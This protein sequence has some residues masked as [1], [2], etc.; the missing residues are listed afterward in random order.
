MDHVPH[1][2]VKFPPKIKFYIRHSSFGFKTLSLQLK[3]GLLRPVD[4]KYRGLIFKTQI[5]DFLIF[6]Q[7]KPFWSTIFENKTKTCLRVFSFEKSNKTSRCGRHI[8][9]RK[10]GHIHITLREKRLGQLNDLLHVCLLSQ[11]QHKDV[12][13]LPRSAFSL[14]VRSARRL[15]VFVI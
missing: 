1:Y 2:G 5:T 14:R 13:I 11:L 8:F 4:C 12:K 6:S 15:L 7:E 10:R 9:S 3:Y